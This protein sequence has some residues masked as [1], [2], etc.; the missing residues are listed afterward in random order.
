MSEAK[1]KARLEYDL[2]EHGPEVE[3]L[4]MS[5]G[6]SEFELIAEEM[7]DGLLEWLTQVARRRELRLAVER[8]AEKHLT[9][10]TAKE[11]VKDTD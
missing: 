8:V 10:Q 11:M 1:L 6:E 9:N 2:M 4:L 3:S 5:D 7:P